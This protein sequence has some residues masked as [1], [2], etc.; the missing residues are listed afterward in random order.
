MFQWFMV[1]K[2]AGKIINLPARLQGPGAQRLRAG[3]G[4]RT[5]LQARRKIPTSWRVRTISS[6]FGGPSTVGKE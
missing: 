2:F 6:E 1:G 3:V 4:R 5:A